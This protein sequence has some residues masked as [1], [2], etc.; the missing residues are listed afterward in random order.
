ML[1]K[2][3]LSFPSFRLITSTHCFF[4]FVT[5]VDSGPGFYF[6]FGLWKSNEKSIAM[7]RWIRSSTSN[8]LT[9]KPPAQQLHPANGTGLQLP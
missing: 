6:I 7:R 4:F 1:R 3:F 2:F 9:K 8:V 5:P